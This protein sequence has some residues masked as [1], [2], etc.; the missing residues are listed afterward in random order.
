MRTLLLLLLLLTPAAAADVSGLDWTQRQGAP[1]PVDAPLRDATG[2]ATSLRQVAGGRA[3]ILAPGYFHCPNL[4][5]VVR[6][7]LLSGLS[8]MASPQEYV[9]ALVTIDPAETPAD[10]S[11]ALRGIRDRYPGLP[12]RALTGPAD[13]LAAI[14]AAAGFNARFDAAGKEFLHPA[15]VA[16]A[17]PAGLVSGY[18]LGL[19]YGP[20]TL[21][22]ALALANAGGMAA[23]EPVHLFCFSYDPVTGRLS[24]AVMEAVRLGAIVTVL[25]VGV[26]IYAL[27]RRA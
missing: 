17:T 26:F 16:F 5:G 25:G 2:Q 20:D 7:D 23:A 22:A 12:V 6:E 3:L 8:A 1:L 18:A 10:A 13:S 24:L 15:G 19:G 21:S 27:N 11:A 4:C 14:A 9:V